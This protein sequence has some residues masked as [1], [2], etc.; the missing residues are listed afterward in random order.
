MDW[1]NLGEGP[2]GMIAERLLANDVADYV[3]FRAVCLPWRRCCM[4]PREHGILD[5]R[6]HPRRWIMLRGQ[7]A[8]PH[9]DRP[10]RRL[11]NVST[12]QCVRTH[13]P[14]LRG[15]EV[16]APTVEGLLVLL[17]RTT[18]AVRL[19]NPLTRQVSDL[20]PATTLYPLHT[21]AGGCLYAT[22]ANF[23]V[24]AAGLANDTTVAVL[25]NLFDMLAVAKPGDEQWTLV[26]QGIEV[27]P[28]IS[29]AGRFY[30]TTASG[31]Q[32]VDIRDNQ[33]PG[34][35]LA[36]TTPDWNER[37]DSRMLLDNDGEL[38]LLTETSRPRIP[39]V[40]FINV[41]KVSRVDLDTGE[42]KPI[43]DLGGRAVFTGE[44]YAFSVSP[45][46][47]PA[48][49]KNSVYLNNRYVGDCLIF[50]G[51]Y[52]F[53]DGTTISGTTEACG[54]TNC[55]PQYGPH[56]IVDNLS[57]YVKTKTLL[58]ADAE[59]DTSDSDAEDDTSDS[60]AEDDISDLDVEAKC[61]I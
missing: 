23:M 51:P 8:H 31:I 32:M 2:A 49:K 29:F 12:G 16:C 30:V 42:M 25:F 19:L 15:H 52:T 28:A 38:L 20:P 37:T 14:E 3:C 46:A 10:R 44:S 60:D 18:Y 47:F 43:R 34:L 26:K 27:W 57:Q 56:S 4:D 1:S 7:L 58:R 53:V 45:S 17:N 24:S 33:P 13:L 59:D 41:Y 61:I 35:V 40:G 50:T 54:F 36:A 48:I 39:Q 21:A 9:P 6:F 55:I 5:R 22:V 11:L